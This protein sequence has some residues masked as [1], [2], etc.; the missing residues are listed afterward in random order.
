MAKPHYT[1][2][3]PGKLL[4]AGEYAVTE[5]NQD[6]IV[7]A[8]DRYITVEV[9]PSSVNRLELPQLGLTDV[10]W[11]VEAGE[12]L[13]SINDDRLRFIKSVIK[14]VYAYVN[15][16]VDR[17]VTLTVKSELDDPSGQKYGLGS[18][19]AIVVAVV[20]ALLKWYQGS[21]DLMT[22]FKLA[23]AAHFHTQGNGSC[24][25]IAASTFGG[26][27]QYRTFDGD[28]LNQQLTEVRSIKKIIDGPWPGLKI[29]PIQLPPSL[30]FLVGWTG[31][32]ASTAPMVHNIR[33]LKQANP[34]TYD[35]FLQQSQQAVAFILDGFANNQPE[36][37]LAGVRKNRQALQFIS[38]QAQV[39]IE[40]PVLEKLATL[41]S[42]YG[43]AKSSGAGGGDCG[44]AFVEE[45]ANVEQLKAEWARSGITPLDLQVA[46][47][48][49]GAY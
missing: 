20:T 48:G 26:W 35:Q 23:S 9:Y 21:E 43:S 38:N 6:S 49:V 13:F 34:S 3:A 47:K 42:K 44:I 41:A 22:I 32:A 31:N 28:W 37:V 7:V 11:K 5:L 29:E 30:H 8:V 4:I 25:D 2:K 18:S 27:I 19:A 36:L 1:V 39:V 33:Q 14:L 46:E 40:T 12:V 15:K 10:Q 17:A 16:D 45:Q 24:A